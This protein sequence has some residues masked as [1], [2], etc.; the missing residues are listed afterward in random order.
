[1]QARDIAGFNPNQAVAH[2]GLLRID[3]LRRDPLALEHAQTL[4]K[5][6]ESSASRQEMPDEEA[7]AHML[8]GVALTRAGK[9]PEAQIHLQKA[10]AMREQMDAPESPLLAEARLHLAQQQ[11]RAGEKDAARKLVD[12]AV[13]AHQAQQIGPQ[14][15][16]LLTHTRSVVG[17]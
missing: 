7:A 14:H 2:V 4:L 3:L 13:R 1:V 5:N 9:L 6:I 10:V 12:Q 11:Y 16:A 15:R 8:L 17:A